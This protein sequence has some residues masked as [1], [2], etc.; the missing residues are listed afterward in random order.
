MNLLSRFAFLQVADF[1][2]LLFM[3]VPAGILPGLSLVLWKWQ[4][5]TAKALTLLTLIYFSFFYFQAYTALHYFIPV[6][7]IPLIVFWRIIIHTLSESKLKWTYAATTITGIAALILS[8]PT[9]FSID[10]SAQAVGET[11]ENRV[12]G[13]ESHNPAVY[14]SAALF[15]DLFPYDWDPEVPD[16]SYGGSTLVWNFYT[17]H[18]KDPHPL[19]NYVLQDLHEK[20][21]DEMRLFASN[22]EF[23]LYIRDES[24][25]ASQRAL[26]PNTPAG[27]SLYII[28][29]SFLFHSVSSS[30]GPAIIN[31]LD[32]L[33]NAGL[34]V[35][36]LLQKLGIENPK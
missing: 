17:F 33:Q 6:M 18:K 22:S 23:G 27:S 28:P 21:P 26:R 16:R 35:S 8:F 19:I 29:R 15:T 4:D 34:N 1:R 25:L 12:P 20:P 2:R 13:Y 30:G 10:T 5:Q 7:L 14:R 11:I 9:S 31:V 3:I 24:V 32:V 36:P